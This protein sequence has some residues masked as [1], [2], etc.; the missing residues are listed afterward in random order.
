MGYSCQPGQEEGKES[1]RPAGRAW[2]GSGRQRGARNNPSLVQPPGSRGGWPNPISRQLTGPSAHSCPSSC[3]KPTEIR[4][5]RTGCG[6]ARMQLGYCK[7][8]SEQALPPFWFNQELTVGSVQ[9][10][11][12][13]L[14]PGFELQKPPHCASLPPSTWYSAVSGANAF[15]KYVGSS[16]RDLPSLPSRDTLEVPVLAER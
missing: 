10:G 12:R 7:P 4:L 16:T 5:A 1:G 8:P 13:I 14:N 15:S 2:A 3:L 9:A 6:P 11:Q